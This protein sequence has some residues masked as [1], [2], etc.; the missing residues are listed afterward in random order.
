MSNNVWPDLNEEMKTTQ[1]VI[2]VQKLIDDLEDMYEDHTD[3]KEYPLPHIVS[4]PQ[5]LPRG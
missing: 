5:P 1:V 2:F 3:G 4:F